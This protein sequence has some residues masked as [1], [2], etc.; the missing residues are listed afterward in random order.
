MA[1][2]NLPAQTALA[3]VFLHSFD[4]ATQ[5]NHVIRNLAAAVDNDT[6]GLVAALTAQ[7]SNPEAERS[8]QTF[9]VRAIER[10]EPS[11]AAS[12]CVQYP[13]LRDV[14]LRRAE[15]HLSASHTLLCNSPKNSGLIIRPSSLLSSTTNLLDG[16]SLDGYASHSSED[17]VSLTLAYLS[18]MRQ[19]F[20]VTS[21]ERSLTLSFTTFEHLFCLLA[22]HNMA[23][24]SYSRDACFSFIAAY[25]TKAL[26]VS[27]SRAGTEAMDQ[28]LWRCIDSLLDQ[29]PHSSYLTTSY[30]I[31]LRWLDASSVSHF[32][33]Q[34][35]QSNKYWAHLLNALARGDVEQRKI[36]LHILRISVAA[37]STT[38]STK[39]MVYEPAKSKSM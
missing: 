12:L 34:V 19:T 17:M 11:I 27:S 36:C 9:L 7:I 30:A 28:H 8:L 15:D 22:A 35:M 29:S 3:N 13:H 21:P 1:Q 32:F 39:D 26:Q 14:L 37:L 5:R 10:G 2:T 4:T 24:A 20:R 18:F 6:V 16:L 25:K 33:D 38:I 23:I 31:W